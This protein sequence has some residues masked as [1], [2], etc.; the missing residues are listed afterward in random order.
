[1]SRD[2]RESTRVDDESILHDDEELFDDDDPIEAYCVHCREM[3]DIENP[4]PVWTRKGLPATRGECPI[5]GGTVFRMGKTAAHNRSTRPAA[6]NVGTTKRK[7][8]KLPQ[9]TVYV[10]FA[11]EDELIAERI[12]DDLRKTG[13]AV[14]LHEHSESGVNWAGG[15]HPAL[16]ECARMVVVLSPAA[17]GVESVQ[18]AWQFFKGKRKPIV[19]AQVIDAEPP[20]AIRRSPRF[21]LSGDYKSAFRQMV[22]ALS[23]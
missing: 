3:I 11:L 16:T 9:D 2:V 5:C 6:V 1:M 20:D 10:T 7:R 4:I 23:Q 18:A 17:L 12:A 22:Q 8:P 13:V 19:I 14:W 15:V 21:D